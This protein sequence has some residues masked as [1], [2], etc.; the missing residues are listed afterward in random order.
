M[1]VVDLLLSNKIILAGIAYGFVVHFK[2]YPIIYAPAL[3]L[4]IDNKKSLLFSWNKYKFGLVSL[5][6][7]L[8]FLG[9]FYVIYGQ[10]FLYE[11]LL[12]HLYRKDHRHNFSIYFYLILYNYEN[13]ST[14][15]SLSAFLP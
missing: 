9:G 14:L 6:V 12:Y 7:F 11:S 13:M 1:I 2:L 3:F 8:L 10:D 4:W 15:Y 5:L